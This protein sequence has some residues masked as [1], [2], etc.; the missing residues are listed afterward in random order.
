MSLLEHRL[1]PGTKRE[2]VRWLP[3][4]PGIIDFFVDRTR[5]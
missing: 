3:T 2:E 5:R 4:G 1:Y